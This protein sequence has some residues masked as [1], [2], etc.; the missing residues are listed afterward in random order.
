[1]QILGGCYYINS[2]GILQN[3][4]LQC[5]V[6]MLLSYFLQYMFTLTKLK[7]II[8]LLTDL[9]SY[10][11]THGIKKLVNLMLWIYLLFIH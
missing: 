8:F 2:L 6:I 3:H 1:M 11:K 9:F 10:V 7:C 5:F 4:V